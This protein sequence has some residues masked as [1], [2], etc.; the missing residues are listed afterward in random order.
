MSRSLNLFQSIQSSRAFMQYRRLWCKAK[1]KRIKI[2]TR[3]ILNLFNLLFHSMWMSTSTHD[4]KCNGT[5]H[6]KW[7]L[8]L[9]A[10]DMSALAPIRF[11]LNV[12]LFNWSKK[13]F[14]FLALDAWRVCL[15][16]TLYIYCSCCCCRRRRRWIVDLICILGLPPK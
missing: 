2:N 1:F 7:I 5:P 6:V 14:Y 15:S 9:G 16:I 12:L 3:R 13:C 11:Q 4:R 8:V 10:C